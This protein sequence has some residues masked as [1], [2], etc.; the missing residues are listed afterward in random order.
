MPK[1]PG[2]SGKEI[3]RALEKLGFHVARQSGSHILM[4]RNEKGCV[5]PNHKEVKVG[6]INGILRQAA[7]SPE[8]FQ[9]ALSN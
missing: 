6:T 3:V 1:F 2:L 9:Q 7:I 8:E 4:K 5:V